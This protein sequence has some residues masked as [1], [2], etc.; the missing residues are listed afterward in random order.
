MRK[1]SGMTLVEV[2]VAVVILGVGLAGIMMSLSQCL[3]LMRVSKEFLDAQWVLQL[4]ELNNPIRETAEVEEKV[5]V[6][7]ESLDEFLSD[8]LRRRGY[9]F[10]REVDPKEESDD[11]EDDGLW[12]VRSRVEW[13]GVRYSGAKGSSEEVVRLVLEKK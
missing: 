1:N 6:S 12:V 7:P 10:S 9:L 5:P 3:G 11:I 8:E 2:L 4:G 13:G